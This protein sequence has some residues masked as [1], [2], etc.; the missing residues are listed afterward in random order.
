MPAICAA[1]AS[2]K[3]CYTFVY[4]SHDEG[5]EIEIRI[6]P[7]VLQRH[8]WLDRQEVLHTWRTAWKMAPRLG[9]EPPETMA[10]GWDSHGRLIELI[11]YAAEDG[12]P[13]IFHANLAQKKFLKELHLTEFEIRCLIGRR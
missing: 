3:H 1:I 11:A 6:H 9:C 2:P 7:R 12:T 8:P 5:H 10:L 4:K 13:I